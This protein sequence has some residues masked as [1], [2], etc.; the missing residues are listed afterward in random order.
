MKRLIINADDFGLTRGSNEG[1][2]ESM[3]NGVVTSTTIMINMCKAE[4]AINLAK[5]NGIDSIGIHLT[6]T[7]GKP[8]LTIE[9]VPSLVDEN[10]NFYNRRASLFPVMKLEEVEKELRA[11]IEKALEIGIKL[12]HIDSHHHI[13]MYDGIREIVAN[14]AKEYNLPLRLANKESWAYYEELGIKTTDHFTWD[15]YG[16]GATLSNFKEIIN[17]FEKGTMEIMCHPAYV[18]DELKQISSYNDYRSNELSILTS[19]ELKEY[20][21]IEKINLISFKD[22]SD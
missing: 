11:Q 1:I 16:D 3:K 17:S 7:C 13:H 9:E 5:E 4:E 2:V 20:L 18:D 19:R 14:L 6:L 12:T 22:L 15:F 8:I 10:G 21:N